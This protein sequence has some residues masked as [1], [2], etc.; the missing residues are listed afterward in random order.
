MFSAAPVPMLFRADNCIQKLIRFNAGK[1]V[2][3][4]G[5]SD[6]QPGFVDSYPKRTDFKVA[7][8]IL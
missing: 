7:Y 1:T 8:E 3:K 5:R 4:Q 2:V 6:M